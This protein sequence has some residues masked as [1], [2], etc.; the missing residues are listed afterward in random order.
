MANYIVKSGKSEYEIDCDRT[1]QE[2]RDLLSSFLNSELFLDPYELTDDDLESILQKRENTVLNVRPSWIGAAGLFYSK[3]NLIKVLHNQDAYPWVQLSFQ[4]WK[5]F[6]IVTLNR[7]RRDMVV[8]LKNENV[9]LPEYKKY[10]ILG[11]REDTT[12]VSY[13]ERNVGRD[14]IYCYMFS[15]IDGYNTC[16]SCLRFA[17]ESYKREAMVMTG[18]FSINYLI[19][20][21]AECFPCPFLVVAC[22]CSIGDIGAMR[23]ILNPIMDEVKPELL[24]IQSRLK[25]SANKHHLTVEEF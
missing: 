1:E 25:D 2:Y 20:Y 3:C 24:K 9:L 6:P 7:F 19:G 16:R 8:Y 14:F 4:P 11:C 17:E 10:E 15:A 22:D 21:P 23:F 12:N 13:F 5:H 18:L